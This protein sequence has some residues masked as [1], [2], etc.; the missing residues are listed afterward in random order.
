MAASGQ[1]HVA[2]VTRIRVVVRADGLSNFA[3]AGV[4][5]ANDLPSDDPRYRKSR[6]RSRDR[7]A[8]QQ[9]STFGA[10]KRDH[11]A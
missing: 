11:R 9:T 1:F 8:R 7:I 4:E 5:F 2:A 10:G 3:N 6:A